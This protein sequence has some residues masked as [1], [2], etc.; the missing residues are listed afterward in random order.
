MLPWAKFTTS[1]G[2][3]DHHEGPGAQARVRL[4]PR[5]RCPETICWIR[6]SIFKWGG[7]E[8]R[9][10]PQRHPHRFEP[11]ARER[12]FAFQIPFP[13]FETFLRS[14]FLRF[15]SSNP[16][17]SEIGAA[18]DWRSFFLSSAAG[19]EHHGPGPVLEGG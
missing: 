10:S 15:V 5:W 3:V 16:S 1:V 18:A 2:L 9:S 14:V 6:M 19:P 4:P 17:V 11:R 8:R 13:R 12:R 7:A